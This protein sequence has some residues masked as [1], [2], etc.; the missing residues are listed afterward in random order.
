MSESRHRD[1]RE[2]LNQ[3]A[4]TPASEVTTHAVV[5]ANT[6]NKLPPGL[7]V[8]LAAGLMVQGLTAY[9]LLKLPPERTTPC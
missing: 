3:I 5:D 6:A 2:P 8:D 1:D 9:L 4:D 7:D